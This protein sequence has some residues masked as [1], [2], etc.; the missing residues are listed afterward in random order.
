MDVA[1]IDFSGGDQ[2]EHGQ[3]LDLLEQALLQRPD[4]RCPVIVDTEGPQITVLNIREEETLQITAGQVL[5]IAVDKT[6]ESDKNQIVTSFSSL[7]Q[8]AR[9][10]SL[11]Y[12][13]GKLVTQVIETGEVS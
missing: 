12:I 6:I 4:R 5:K 1:R 13:G 9:I 3:S 11:L 8:Y 2:K 7:P 10:D